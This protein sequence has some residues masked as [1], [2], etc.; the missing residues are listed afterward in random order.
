MGAASGSA[1]KVNEDMGSVGLP[2]P[3]GRQAALDEVNWNPR[4][5]LSSRGNRKRDGVDQ[6]P[7]L[8]PTGGARRLLTPIHGASKNFPTLF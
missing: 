3:T 5:T 8:A 1:S 4:S 7:T 2:F 6:M